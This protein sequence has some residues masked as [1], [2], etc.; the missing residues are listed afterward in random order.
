MVSSPGFGSHA[1]NSSRPIQTLFPCAYTYRLKL[2]T[3]TNSLTHYAKGTLSRFLYVSS[4]QHI[5]LQLLVGIRFQIYFTPLLGV[6]F[7]FPSRYF[8]SIDHWVVL[9]LGGWSPLLQTEFLVLRLTLV[10]CIFLLVRGY[11]PLRPGFPSCSNSLYIS[12]W[13]V[14]FRSPLLSES[15]LISFP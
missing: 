1:S 10:I 6:L 9:R 8:S 13:L 5:S 11:H 4:R 15:L 12:T 14:R 2:A 3:N 7:T